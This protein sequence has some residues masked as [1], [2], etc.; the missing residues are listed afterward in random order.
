MIPVIYDCDPGHDDAV[1]LFI[2]LA[3]EKINL[4]G[5]TTSAG[6]QLQE[7]TYNNA[8]KLLAL[9]E[10]E[11][12]LVCSGAEKPLLRELIIA[13]NIHGETGL[14]GAD[15]PQPVNPPNSTKAWDF[16]ADILKDSKEPVCLVAT[17][18]LTNVA[19]F[20]LAYPELKP[21]IK[22]I[23]IMGGACFGGNITPAAEFNIYVDPEAADIVF[24][25]GISIKMFGL[26]VT[27]KARMLPDEIDKL[28]QIGNMTGEIFSG[29]LKFFLQS[30][31]QYFLA[32]EGH[33][34]GV[35]LHDPCTMAYL[36]DPS[37]FRMYDCF[38]KVETKDGPT[39]G[40]TIV[41]Y[42]RVTG[43]PFNA[44]VAFDIKREQFVEL[45]LETMKQFR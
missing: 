33:I 29:L 13:D 32:E 2:A 8:R 20:L 18:P 6:N 4:L 42:N 28:E 7:K 26:D 27:M 3:S 19:I 31:S 45:V 23:I 24:K 38:V 14:D 25:S 10:R 17:G 22:E 41:D 15:L 40:S 9:A 44:S 1:A 21:L 30:S 43:N 39:R 35:H 36:I 16:I 37:M 12:V 5:I 11:G 34:E